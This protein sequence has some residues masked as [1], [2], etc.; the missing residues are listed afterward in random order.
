MEQSRGKKY[1]ST[2]HIDKVL[3]QQTRT[4]CLVTC[5]YITVPGYWETKTY[6]LLSTVS[7]TMLGSGT[8]RS[9][10]HWLNAVCSW[11]KTL[12][13][14]GM[15]LYEEWRLTKEGVT[16]N[17]TQNLQERTGSDKREK[18]RKVSLTNERKW[19]VCSV[20]TGG[21]WEHVSVPRAYHRDL[22][23]QS[24]F[25]KQFTPLTILSMCQSFSRAAASNTH[26][27]PLRRMH[28][29]GPTMAKNN[30]NKLISVS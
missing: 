7:S 20:Q 2:A 12:T 30:N 3:L 14:M 6:F 19:L 13:K 9:F 11:T 8:S 5:N 29:T 18:T 1:N 17:H 22:T 27:P 4:L 23:V 24:V 15:T 16:G 21:S 10:N 26:N 25:L 28:R